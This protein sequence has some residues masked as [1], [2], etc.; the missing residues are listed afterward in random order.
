MKPQRPQ[1]F[2]GPSRSERSDPPQVQRRPAWANRS[3]HTLDLVFFD[4][5]TT[6][7]NPDNSSVIEVAAIKFSGGKEVG[8]YQSLVNPQRHIP[9]QVVQITGIS[10][11][12]VRDAP[13]GEKV[14][15]E[16]LDFIGEG[17]LVAHG[18]LNDFSFVNHWSIKLRSRM[19]ENYYLCTHL[20]VTNFLP[21]IPSKTLSGVA[22]YFGLPAENAHRALADAEMTADVFWKIFQSCEKNGFQT[23]ED[24]IKIQADNQSLRRLGAGISQREV[25][26]APTT[27]GVIYF[28]NSQNEVAY[29]TA[30]PSVKRT[31]KE[32]TSLGDERELNKLIVDLAGFKF[33]RT[34]HLLDALMRERNEL[35][36]MQLSLDAR[37]VEGRAE[38]MVQI[39]VPPDMIAFSEENPQLLESFDHCVSSLHALSAPGR[40]SH[41]QAPGSL[42]RAESDEDHEA[43]EETS[44]HPGSGA[45]TDVH[46]TAVNAHWFG[47][48]GRTEAFVPVRKTRRALRPARLDK[49]QVDRRHNPAETIRF[50]HLTEGV[51]WALGP[52]QPYKAVKKQME[53]LLLRFP[54]HNRN[55]DM[56][57]RF[58]FLQT[59][60]RIARGETKTLVDELQAERR[61]LRL[62]LSGKLRTLHKVL[63]SNLEEII[64]LGGDKLFQRD[65]FPRSGLVLITN[66]ESKELDVYVV[67]CGR[68][69]QRHSLAADQ[70]GKIA[71]ARYFTRLFAEYSNEIGHEQ[72]VIPFTEDTCNNLEL[73]SYWLNHPG[74]DGEWID[75]SELETLFDPS[76]I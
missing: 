65:P 76:L 47:E 34:P 4:L 59:V 66:H 3:L 61:S 12:T 19:L 24:L 55:F 6:G 15:D 71:S 50:G 1:P 9:R 46:E 7:G 70:S 72:Q 49:Y 57:T 63:L 74:R 45:S 58:T 20:L 8:R 33:E 31:L 56:L 52:F 26:L 67:V 22:D 16:F 38:G 13:P 14:F 11:A 23:L 37:K 30:T 2:H 43:P 36:R 10:N 53:E 60:L 32:F 27:S 41:A 42:Y 75:F 69:R 35:R 18:V 51:G 40:H 48:E 5:E 44:P 29:V 17:V 39:L 25:E 73:F 21:N 68:V 54:F 62:L 64:E 28:F